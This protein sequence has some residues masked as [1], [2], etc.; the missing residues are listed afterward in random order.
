ML[1]PPPLSDDA[2]LR[3]GD[4]VV[5]DFGINFIVTGVIAAKIKYHPGEVGGVGRVHSIELE[6]TKPWKIPHKVRL[7][8]QTKW[9]RYASSIEGT[10]KATFTGEASKSLLV[11]VEAAL[12]VAESNYARHALAVAVPF[13]VYNRY[14]YAPFTRESISIADA[15]EEAIQ[16]LSSKINLRFVRAHAAEIATMH[17]NRRLRRPIFKRGKLWNDNLKML[18]EARKPDDGPLDLTRA[19][20]T[21]YTFD[22]HVDG[23][24]ASIKGPKSDVHVELLALKNETRCQFAIES[25]DGPL[26]A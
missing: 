12:E 26:K 20:L 8:V 7:A 23:W 1:M 10:T 6:V 11:F 4:D 15:R 13:A 24:R 22:V 25:K 19:L 16:A 3:L 14:Q 9:R 17:S 18:R 21:L 5:D 2:P